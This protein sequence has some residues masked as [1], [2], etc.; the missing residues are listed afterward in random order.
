MTLSDRIAAHASRIATLEATR[1]RA[2]QATTSAPGTGQAI[3]GSLIGGRALNGP[4]RQ[5]RGGPCRFAGCG[6]PVP[7][8]SPYAR[9]CGDPCRRRASGE[10]KGRPEVP[11]AQRCDV[12]RRNKRK[13]YGGKCNGCAAQR[14]R[15]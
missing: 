5:P 7:E 15:A 9:W 13:P 3:D 1:P 10:V 8:S 6:R 14:R 2:T 4:A 11:E 12:C